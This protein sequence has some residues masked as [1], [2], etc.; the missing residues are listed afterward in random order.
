[1]QTSGRLFRVA[2]TDWLDRAVVLRARQQRQDAEFSAINW[3]VETRNL[4][5]SEVLRFSQRGHGRW[6][7]I[8]KTM[9]GTTFQVDIHTDE[10]LPVKLGSTKLD[11]E[12]PA[13]L[14]YSF[15]PNGSVAVIMSPHSSAHAG[16]HESKEV[17]SSFV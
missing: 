13:S 4:I 2:L 1:M 15:H 16:N 17:P 8:P 5:E 3:R 6:V 12:S 10:L 9:L 14:V 7:V 11:R